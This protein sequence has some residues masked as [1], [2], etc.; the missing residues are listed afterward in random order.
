MIPFAHS[1]FGNINTSGTVVLNTRIP[2]GDMQGGTDR[3]KLAGDMQSG[4]DVRKTRE[5]L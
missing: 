1:S 4:S 2:R 5:T 3:R